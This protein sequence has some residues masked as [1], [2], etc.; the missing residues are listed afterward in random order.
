VDERVLTSNCLRLLG[1]IK[2]K[3][4]F[5]PKDRTKRYKKV[6]ADAAAGCY[7]PCQI[8]IEGG[9]VTDKPITYEALSARCCTDTT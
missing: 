3:E 5:G 2:Y 4:I 7:V 8:D 6:E 1:S 9:D